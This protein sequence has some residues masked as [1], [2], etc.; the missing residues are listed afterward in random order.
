MLFRYYGLNE[1]VE[2]DLL[3]ELDTSGT[4]AEVKSA[5]EARFEEMIA[6]IGVRQV[7]VLT[8]S[9]GEAPGLI[10]AAETIYVAHLNG[11]VKPESQSRSL[12][13]L[14]EDSVPKH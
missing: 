14:I 12:V 3:N 8:T 9:L 5:V 6:T 7:L 13:W 11:R 10:V 4:F 2:L 1:N